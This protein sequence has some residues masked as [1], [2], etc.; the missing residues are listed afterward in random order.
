MVGVV[1][2][3]YLIA[4]GLL[5]SACAG[6][7]GPTCTPSFPYKNGWLGGDAGYSI[8]LGADQ[9]LWLFGDTFVATEEQGGRDTAKLVANSV[10]L[11]DCAGGVF[12]IAYYWRRNKEKPRPIFEARDP[13]VRYWPLDGFVQHDGLY[14]FLLR[15][16]TTNASEALGF[17]LSGVDLAHVPN[18]KAAP[19]L[20][21]TR[22]SI[23]ER[24]HGLY[25]GVAAVPWNDRV[26]LYTADSRR[27][28]ER[29]MVISRLSM[30][31]MENPHLALEYLHN[32]GSWGRL[33]SY[34]DT[35]TVME[36][37]VMEMSVRYNATVGKWVAVHSSPVVGQNEIELRTAESLEGPW[38][39][40]GVIYDIPDQRPDELRS[41]VPA[42]CYA[43]K[44]HA[45]YRGRDSRTLVVTYACNSFEL[46]SLHK[47]LTLYRPEAVRVRV[48]DA[49]YE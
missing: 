14:V 23:V 31:S 2:Y 47:D 19:A 36:D 43:G 39:A 46:Q 25:P 27:P 8:P 40:P 35:R 32:D 45:Q 24:T 17:E 30:M 11:S 26:V 7:G 49:V 41:E 16:R 44:E 21:K 9:S 29:R 22:Y 13:G 20:W 38:S 48:S 34:E 42:F 37:A 6:G 15:V 1:R 33:P 28:E 3:G 5:L 18:Y 12:D 10:A 4:I